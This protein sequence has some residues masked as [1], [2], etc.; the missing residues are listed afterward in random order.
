MPHRLSLLARASVAQYLFVQ[1]F[2]LLF[3]LFLLA[4]AAAAQNDNSDKYYQAEK[5]V[6]TGERLMRDGSKASLEQALQK[7]EQARKLFHSIKNRWREAYTVVNMGDVYSSLDDGNKALDSYTQVLAIPLT[8]EG[9]L[10]HATAR[11]RIGQIHLD[12]E[13]KRKALDNLEKGAELFRELLFVEFEAA[14]LPTL[15]GLYNDLGDKEKALATL[16]RVLS[17]FRPDEKENKAITLTRLALI[18]E[19]SREIQ[20]ALDC[21]KE[22]LLLA[23]ALKD[24]DLEAPIRT[25]FGKIYLELGQE[26]MALANYLRA[27]DISKQLKN[28]EGNAAIL[29]GL[30]LTLHRLN[31]PLKAL[32]KYAEALPVFQANKN[33]RSLALTYNNIGAVYD[34]LDRKPEALKNFAK[35]LEIFRKISDRPS[36]AM[37]LNNIGDAYNDLQDWQQ[38]FV[39]Y[40]EALPLYRATANPAGEATVL[41]GLAKSEEGRG[42]LT[43]ARQRIRA[44]ISIV[45][46]LRTKILNQ[47]LR[48]SYFATVQGKYQYYIAL[49]MRLHRQSP[50][51]GYDGEALQ[52]NEQARARA[53]LETLAEAGAEIRQGVDARILE[54]ERSLQNQL[55]A[56]AFQQMQLGGGANN[57]QKKILAE[58]VNALAAELQAVK[59]EIRRTSPRYAAL[60]QPQPR[61]LKAIQSEVLDEDTLLLEYSLGLEHSYLW[62]VTKD[63]ISS[64]QLPHGNDIHAAVY[65]LDRLVNARNRSVE[66]ETNAQRQARVMRADREIPAAAAS[67]SRMVLAP[68][69]AQLGSKRLVIVADGGLRY[70]PFALLP[71]PDPNG[72]V[73]EIKTGSSG[74]G[75]KPLIV[76][77]EIVS[78]DSASTLALIRR[79]VAQ[80]PLAPK[81]VAVLADPV[82]T[83]NDARVRAIPGVKNERTSESQPR[84]ASVKGIELVEALENVGV[85][86]GGLNVPRLPGTRKEAEDIVAMVPPADRMLALDFAASREM[87]TNPVL[88][89]YRYVHF[90]THGILNGINPELSGLVFSLVKEN[91]ETQDGFLRAHEVFNLKL[92][93]EVVVLSACETGIGK[94]ISGEGMVSLTRGFMYAGAPRVVVS[95]WSVSEWGT[96]ELMVRFYRGIL[97]DGLRPA[98]ALRAAQISLIN[99]AQWGSPYYWAPFTLQGEWR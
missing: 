33:R 16:K 6:G 66:G 90:S 93:A 34:D 20:N 97:K 25:L 11:R 54:R 59:T 17:F 7:F 77:H 88:S 94:E 14:I 37:T 92:P 3:L 67:L 49:L 63:S 57:E 41:A 75:A 36:Q 56:K 81:Q 69:A 96:T 28:P 53:L 52:V 64:Y 60:T 27:L 87:A 95:L 9:R 5:L 72:S 70:I 2:L 55:D 61:S 39:N 4:G 58:Q 10:Y 45:E 23:E 74:S 73:S 86:S 24:M 21:L 71:K 38:A 62:A 32:E 29:V 19:Q 42:N 30:G 85:T 12:R 13:D 84:D 26:E 15:G 8:G 76:D 35:A 91:G 46:S 22:A 44:A 68:V 31:Q 65:L 82:F 47:E 79:E 48:S 50:K 43:E 40:S 78:L 89:Q 51:D 99:D 98:A 1:L 83:V 18:Y 80:R